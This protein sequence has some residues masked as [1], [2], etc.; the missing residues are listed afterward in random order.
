[1]FRT[2]NHFRANNIIEL[3][4][5]LGITTAYLASANLNGNVY[6]FEGAKQVAAI[7]KQTFDSLSINNIQVIEGNFDD[8][9]QKQLNKMSCVDFAFVDGNHRKKP[10]IQYFEQLLEK[11]TESSVF[12][13]T[14]Y[15]GAKKWKKRG[16]ILNN[17]LL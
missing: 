7:A 5:S 10:T 15:T 1:M 3:G 12:I 14:I 11:S 4:T 8:T 6:T 9:L 17:T 13:L 16:N 2:V